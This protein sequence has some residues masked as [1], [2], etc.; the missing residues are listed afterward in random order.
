MNTKP[1]DVMLASDLWL[2]N[3]RGGKVGRFEK[4]M[5]RSTN[6]YSQF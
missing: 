3:M 6:S 1:V 4:M 5:L 2:Q